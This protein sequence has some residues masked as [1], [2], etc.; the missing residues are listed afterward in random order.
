MG[1]PEREL[2]GGQDDFYSQFAAELEV[3]AEL[4]GGRGP[5]LGLVPLVL[6]GW[7]EEGRRR[8][9]RRLERAQA[10][11]YRSEKGP[12]AP[13]AAGAVACTG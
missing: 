6:E 4:E 2:G 12:P 8:G 1:D 11:A 5:R 7:S 9:T 13:Q 3:L 10:G